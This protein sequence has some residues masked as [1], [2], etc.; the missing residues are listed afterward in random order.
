MTFFNDCSFKFWLPIDIDETFSSFSL[1][2]LILF[3]FSS[4]FSIGDLTCVT[5]AIILVLLSPTN[6]SYCDLEMYPTPDCV[7]GD[8]EGGNI[9]NNNLLSIAFT[10]LFNCDDGDGLIV[11]DC[12]DE[13]IG[14]RNLGAIITS[15]SKPN[16]TAGRPFDDNDV[17]GSVDS[18]LNF[19][20]VDEGR[21]TIKGW[22]GEA[23]LT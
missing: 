5:L 18:M 17:G 19:N 15:V 9:L 10:E 23:T 7:T 14:L 22:D 13:G 4:F 16:N 3:F 11:D 8:N 2:F 6:D 12:S 1:L 21:Y 20:V